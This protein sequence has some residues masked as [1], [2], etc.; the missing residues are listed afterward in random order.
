MASRS[1]RSWMGEFVPESRGNSLL[2]GRAALLMLL[3]F[4][5]L[6]GRWAGAQVLYGA[7]NGVVTDPSGAA[8]PDAKVTA[9][10]MHKGISQETTTGSTGLYRFSA[11]LPG[12]WKITVSASGF[13]SVETANIQIDANNA[14]RVDEK[15][16]IA[17]AQMTVT[18]TG[19]PPAL[20]TD[21]ADVHTDIS[22]EEIQALPQ[23][24]SEGKT[25]QSLLRIIPGATLPQE[26]NSAAGNPARAMT[27]NVNGQSSQGNGTRIDGISDTYPWLPN[28][29]AYVPPSDGIE[30]VNIAT[31]SFDAEQGGVNGAAVNVQ[32]KT[33]SNKFHGDAH[34][35]HTDDQLKALNY[36]ANPA[37]FHRPL[38]IFNQYGGAV[39]GPI[40]KDKLFFFGDWE[41]TRQI[42]APA[43]GNPQTVPFGGLQYSNAQSAGFFDFRPF[44]TAAYGLVDKAGN[45][46]HIYDPLTGNPNGSGR[47]PISCNGIVDT[48]CLNRVDPAALT[49]AKIIPA[50]TAG[51]STLQTNNYLD[52]QKGFFNRDNYDAKVNYVPTQKTTVFGRFSFSN[53]KIFD[54]PSLGAAEGNATNGGQLGN[55][56]TKIYVIGFGATHAFTS[57]LLLD[58]NLGFTRQHLSAL[59][60]DIAADGPY[61]L[62]TLQIPG[63]NNAARPNDQLYWGIPAFSFA[64]FTNIGNPNTGNPFVFRDNQYIENENLTWVKGHHQFRFGE[65]WDHVQMNHFQP[66]GGSFQTARGSF[67][68]TGVATEQATCANATTLTGCT[69]TDAPKTLQ[70]NSYADFL[71]GLPWQVGK[72]TQINNPIALRWN[73][74]AV[75]A[76]DM[77]QATPNL[78]VDLGVRWERFPMAYSDHDKGARVLNPATMQVLLGGYGSTPKDTGVQIGFGEIL[79]RLGIDY[80]IDDKTVIRGGFGIGGDDNNWRYLRND[81]PADIISTFNGQ[82]TGGS[83]SYTQFAPGASLTGLNATGPYAALPVGIQII[84][85]PDFSSGSIPLPNGVTTSTIGY[86][87]FRRGYIY[88]YNLTLEREFA[89]F[90][91][92]LGYVGDKEVRPVINLNINAAPAGG[93]TAGQVLNKQ[94]GKT[95]GSIGQLIPLGNT[96]YDSMQAKVTRRFGHAS[97]WGMVYTWSKAFD[98]EDNEEL[99]GPLWNYSAYFSRNRALAGFDRTS[100]FT[101]YWLYDLPFGKGQR[102]AQNGVLGAIAGGWAFSG[103]LSR[104]SGTPFTITDNSGASNL[105]SPGNQQTPNIVGPIHLTKGKPYQNPSNCPLGTA[106]C[107]YFSTSSFAEVTTAATFGNAGRNII[108]GPGY[109]DIDATITRDFKIREYLTFQFEAQAIGLTNTPHFG[110]PDGNITDANFGKVTGEVAAANASLGG[111]GGER[112]LWFGGKFIF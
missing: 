65:E 38:L 75:Y 81:Y 101:T 108:R 67:Q 8:I 42:Q 18:V 46:V 84:P 89:G 49:L 9:V 4:A 54:P 72:A 14:V 105:N 16:E 7:L 19:A 41:A 23:I 95:W 59:S 34:E 62:K 30:T 74:F 107:S 31:N 57:N 27:S 2:I 86:P 82:A 63:T 110:N 25:F 92:D 61:G 37:T 24:G 104:L 47:S 48:I 79:P 53:G 1:L 111:S 77:W 96:Y 44:Q 40:K 26:N 68:S 99:S 73:Q 109:F 76:R 39:G 103:V 102:W 94:F 93:G 35:F 56:L 98:L 11:M 29:V 15:L 87:N 66:Q 28:N 97:Q 32:I 55:A 91:A 10:E 69:A 3:A 50:P 21:R 5:L 112:Q 106:G 17:K 45:P 12:L 83:T 90:I 60:T 33:G 20:Q 88:S 100:I 64:T 6:A 78:S 58:A 85:A 43:G 71:L 36:F 80:R 22:T 70:F 51:L 52:T 13:N